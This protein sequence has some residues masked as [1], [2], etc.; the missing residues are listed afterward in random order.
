VASSSAVY[1][2]LTVVLIAPSVATAW[3][4]TAYSAQFGL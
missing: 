4:T 2:G 1:R 3:N